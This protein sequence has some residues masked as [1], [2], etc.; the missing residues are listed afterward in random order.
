MDGIK[1]QIS[2]TCAGS[3]TSQSPNDAASTGR[4]LV[5]HLAR[6]GLISNL[7]KL[8][9]GIASHPS[10]Q[11][12]ACIPHASSA[13]MDID[14]C[15]QSN[16]SNG[17]SPAVEASPA[18]AIDNPHLSSS[19]QASIDSAQQHES[20]NGSQQGATANG[21]PLPQDRS[22]ACKQLVQGLM[23]A[24]LGAYKQQPDAQRRACV[25]EMLLILC[26]PFLHERYTCS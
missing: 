3:G 25:Q 14:S 26:Q 15:Q 21:T 13:A 9:A 10:Q 18:D 16:G 22:S 11:G 7:Q 17:S 5:L 4:A 12:A 20:S 24:Y 6:Y 1:W 23:R 2:L 19:Q 8:A